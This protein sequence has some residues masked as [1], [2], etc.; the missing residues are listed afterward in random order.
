MLAVGIGN[1]R[2]AAVDARLA[3]V[4]QAGQPAALLLPVTDRVL[5]E[6]E[7]R[8]LGEV[9]IGKTDL[10]TD[11]RPASSRSEG[12]RFICRNRS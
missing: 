5:D 3:Q 1:Q 4:V 11:C 10:N 2:V 8:V 6:L 12:S 7:R 9:E